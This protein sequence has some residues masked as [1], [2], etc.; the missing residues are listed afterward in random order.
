VKEYS[1]PIYELP[2]NSVENPIIEDIIRSEKEKEKE[3]PRRR[4]ASGDSQQPPRRKPR[5]K[6]GRHREGRDRDGRA[7]SKAAKDY[8]NID[9][10]NTSHDKGGS[11]TNLVGDEVHLKPFGYADFGDYDEVG[12]SLV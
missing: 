12:G 1:N 2:N 6:D 5:S 11:T 4:T 7:P 10:Y 3:R 8:A 9:K